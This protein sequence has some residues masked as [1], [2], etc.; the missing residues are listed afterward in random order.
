MTAAATAT[1]ST[2]AVAP[3]FLPDARLRPLGATVL[4]PRPLGA[5]ILMTRRRLFLGPSA[6]T[7]RPFLGALGMAAG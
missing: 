6:L 4:I 3:G 2:A 1:T 5:T 7:V